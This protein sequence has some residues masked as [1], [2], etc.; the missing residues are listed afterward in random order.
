MKKLLSFIV[1]MTVSTAL[2]GIN[3]PWAKK[4]A[5]KAAAAA[6]PTA[7]IHKEV[8]KLI[9]EN[10][11]LKEEI[12]RLTGDQVVKTL[13]SVDDQVVETLKTIDQQEEVKDQK[14][15][16]LEKQ[17]HYLGLSYYNCLKTFE[18]NINAPEFSKMLNKNLEKLDDKEVAQKINEAMANAIYRLKFMYTEARYLL[19]WTNGKINWE[20]AAS[21]GI[22][23]PVFNQAVSEQ[24]IK[25]MV[26]A[27]E[28]K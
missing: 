26:M 27:V 6:Q 5:E 21:K 14:I 12:A 3:W 8:N 16:D 24:E 2:L 23:A 9:N 25:K 11:K 28:V 10:Q 20:L 15:A 4:P 1:C 18:S 17:V 13:N 22:K 19:N 7:D